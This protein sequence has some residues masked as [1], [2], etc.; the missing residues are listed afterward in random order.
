MQRIGPFLHLNSMFVKKISLLLCISGLVLAGCS[1][2]DYYERPSMDEAGSIKGATAGSPSGDGDGSGQAEGEPG[3]ITAGEWNDLDNWSFWGRL[4]TTE[5]SDQEAGDYR[6]MP[7]YWRFYTDRRV[8]VEVVDQQ[9]QPLNGV[10]VELLSDD[11]VV[12]KSVTDCLGRAEGWVG[13]YDN[14]AKDGVLS[15]ALNGIKQ[16]DAPVVSGWK[17]T[18]TNN[19]YVFF[20]KA[21]AAVADL[22]FIVDATGSMSDEI[23]FLKADLLNIMDK[24][25]KMETAT[26]IRTSAIFYR[27]EGDEY[28]TRVTPFSTDFSA[29]SRFIA[30]QSAAGGG[31]YPEA[32]HTAL[33]AS[34]QELA[35]S[36]SAQAKL[37]FILLDAPPH[38]DDKGVIE[39]IQ[40]TIRHY[41][42]QGIKLIPVAS[43]GVDKNT[44]FLLRF[45][46]IATGGTYVFITNDSGIGN[47]HIAPSVGDYK[48]EILGDLMVRLI[49][50]YIG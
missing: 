21:P 38:H 20:A 40:K 33:E 7:E 25:Q 12:W 31:D 39:S 48:V 22:L 1:R 35:W 47:D 32:V 4:M 16:K 45:M 18:P 14:E 28:L 19:K 26:S 6:K 43:S 44:E 42:A 41:A 2:D 36:S 9:S 30:D 17:E 23:A 27:D 24:V 15:I 10:T 29:T 50:K 49:T 34:I 3:K 11:E 37:A 46:A 5:Q 13:L 8:A